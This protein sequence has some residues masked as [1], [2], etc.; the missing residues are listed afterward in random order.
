MLKYKKL[1]DFINS[2]Q[3]VDKKGQKLSVGDFCIAE[4]VDST[5]VG[6][7]LHFYLKPNSDHHAVHCLLCNEDGLSMTFNIKRLCKIWKV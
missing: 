7:L 1:E 4:S 6:M 5:Y 3:L 2:E